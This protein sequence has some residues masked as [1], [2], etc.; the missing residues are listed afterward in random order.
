MTLLMVRL[1]RA[2]GQRSGTVQFMRAN[3]AY[4]NEVFRIQPRLAGPFVGAGNFGVVEAGGSVANFVG[5]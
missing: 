5:V 3:S 4:Q 2:K 1:P